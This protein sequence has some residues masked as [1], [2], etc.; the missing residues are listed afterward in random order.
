MSAAHTWVRD[1][2]GEAL[3]ETLCVTNPGAAL[4]GGD[5]HLPNADSELSVRKWYE[6]WR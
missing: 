3:A 2:Y 1:K 6:F 5:M 4:G